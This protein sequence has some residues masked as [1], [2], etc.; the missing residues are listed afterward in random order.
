LLQDAI[1]YRVYHSVK[2]PFAEAIHL[3]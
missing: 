2:R 1:S 3:T